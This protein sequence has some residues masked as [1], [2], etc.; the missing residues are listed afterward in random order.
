MAAFDDA[1]LA[2]LLRPPDVDDGD[3]LHP[4]PLQSG[5]VHVN[6]VRMKRHA[7]NDQHGTENDKPQHCLSPP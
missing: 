5:A 6:D 1:G 4:Q 7:A 2:P 3:P